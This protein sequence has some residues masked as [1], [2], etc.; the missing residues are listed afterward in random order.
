MRTIAQDIIIC[1]ALKA[2]ESVLVVGIVNPQNMVER[3]SAYHGI[4]VGFEPVYNRRQPIAEHNMTDP[5]T[6]IIGFTY[7]AA[8]LTGYIF[9][10]K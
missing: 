7:P 9:K 1:Q 6:P 3:L 2:R 10:L 4:E 5:E 8:E